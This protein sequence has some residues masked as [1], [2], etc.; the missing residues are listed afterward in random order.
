LQKATDGW[1][2]SPPEWI[3]AL[4]TAAET[5]G[6]AGAA[7]SIGYS[8]GLVSAVLRNTYRGDV[9]RVAEKVAGA[10]MGA[11]VGC[12]VIGEMSRNT[13]LDWQRKPKAAT[14][15]YRMRMYHACRNNCPNF[16]PNAASVPPIKAEGGS[17]ED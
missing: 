2:G 10:L 7:Q 8:I 11:T 6:L 12:P 3:I 4:A 14:S 15:A 13:C 9:A 1:E 5:T 17:D 16:R